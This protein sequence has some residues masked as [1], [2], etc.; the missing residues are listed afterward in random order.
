MKMDEMK[1]SQIINQ[2]ASEW[3]V[4]LEQTIPSETLDDPIL[5]FSQIDRQ[6]EQ[7]VNQGIE[8]RVAFLRLYPA[9]HRCDRLTALPLVNVGF[10]EKTIEFIRVK[11]FIITGLAASLLLS[12]VLVQQFIPKSQLQ[13]FETV[14]GG[15]QSVPLTDGSV[16]ELNT[17]TRL[18]TEITES[19]RKVT[20]KKGEAYF[21]IAH[22]KERPFLVNVGDK[23]ITVLGTKFSVKYEGEEV[24]V[25]VSE[26]R[27]RVDSLDTTRPRTT[28]IEKNMA[29]LA[30]HDNLLVTKQELEQT[31]A[32]LGWRAGLLIFKQD[33]LAN[34]VKEFNRYNHKKILIK[35]KSIAEIRIG[36]SF[37][38]KNI[39]A[40]VRLLKDG[41]DIQ[42][43]HEKGIII[44]F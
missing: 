5:F 27:V 33:S 2:Q 15:F 18:T 7:W 8:Y 34:I 21:N 36:G 44:I 29:A 35:N 17:N 20:L 39:D 38:A 24:E 1:N 32:D 19:T 11:K 40:F 42:A 31:Q 37:H 28:F 9:W 41:L 4:E 16:L 22:D 26:G 30:S 3:L 43:K 14:V 6:F 13:I 25:I 10:I 12:I 23:R